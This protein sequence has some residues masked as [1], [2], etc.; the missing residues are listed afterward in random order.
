MRLIRKIIVFIISFLV[1]AIVFSLIKQYSV[2][3][4]GPGAIMWIASFLIIFIFRSLFG[5][6]NNDN[7]Q[8]NDNDLTTLNKK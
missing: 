2:A 6:K 3:N 8:E 7:N 1:I 4:G 5:K